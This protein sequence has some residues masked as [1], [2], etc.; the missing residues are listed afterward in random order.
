MRKPRYKNLIR[1]VIQ[2][3]TAGKLEI[4]LKLKQVDYRIYALKYSF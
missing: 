3:L 4:I 2:C 1:A